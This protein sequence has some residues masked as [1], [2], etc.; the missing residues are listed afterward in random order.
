MI[1]SISSPP[2][3]SRSFVTSS[4]LSS[5]PSSILI[6][7]LICLSSSSTTTLAQSPSPS[8]VVLQGKCQ[9]YT[10]K[11]CSAHVAAGSQV[12]I[13]NAL[14]VDAIEG[15][16]TA[17]GLPLL[18]S[19]AS[20][21]AKCVSDF[22]KW[23]CLS[24]FPACEKDA[25][26]YLR[27]NPHAPRCGF[28]PS[29]LHVAPMSAKLPNCA[30]NVLD[31]GVP[32]PPSQP[33][34]PLATASGPGTLAPTTPS[35][36]SV[37]IKCPPPLIRN[38][39]TPGADP[40]RQSCTGDCCIPCPNLMHFYPPR[41]VDSAL[42]VT[43]SMR[44][45]SAA[46]ALIVFLSFLVL[47][48]KRNHPA[49]IILWFS[50]SIFLFSVAVFPNFGPR[51]RR[52]AQ[53]FDSVTQSTQQSNLVCAIQGAFIIFGSHALCYWCSFLIVNLHLVTVWNRNFFQDP[54][55]LAIKSVRFDFG[56]ICNV[57]SEWSNQLFFYP[58]AIV[59]G[60]AFIMHC[61]TVGY[62]ARIAMTV[63]S[64]AGASALG[65]PGRSRS[66]GGS[67]NG[68]GDNGIGEA[69]ADT[70]LSTRTRVMMVWNSSWR[71]I[72]LSIVL[73]VTL[74]IFWCFFFIDVDR[75][76]TYTSETE[77]IRKWF[78]CLFSDGDQT[79]CAYI[80]QPHVPRYWFMV[81]GGD[82]LPSTAGVVAFLIF[83]ARIS[84]WNEWVSFSV[85]VEVERKNGSPSAPYR[86]TKVAFGESD[87]EAMI[88]KD[89]RKEED[90]S[91][92][93]Q[94][95]LSEMTPINN[96]NV[97]HTQNLTN[98]PLQLHRLPV[99]VK[100][101]HK[102]TPILAKSHLSPPPLLIGTH[103]T[104]PTTPQPHPLFTAA[105]PPLP[106]PS[107]PHPP[108]TEADPVTSK[109]NPQHQPPEPPCLNKTTTPQPQ[110]HSRPRAAT[111]RP[112]VIIPAHDRVASASANVDP[113][114]RSHSHAEPTS[115]KM[116]G[117]GEPVSPINE[118]T[119]PV[120]PG[121][122]RRVTYKARDVPVVKSAEVGKVKREQPGGWVVE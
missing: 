78:I 58:L 61:F 62:I 83:G 71:S 21:E 43:D 111:T 119:S 74:G 19:F 2:P 15:N 90:G 53:C 37:V 8:S 80:A 81:I 109:D 107:H 85:P 70:S 84:L 117:Y 32:Y 59:V 86:E 23:S 7:I 112:A 28:L 56:S 1:T 110:P 68:R 108:S 122:M 51:S 48:G 29:T 16:L 4:S 115:P 82:F 38:P 100:S 98:L 96:L 36:A 42:D 57:S 69:N 54:T 88:D 103:P 31:F 67:S 101:T 72:S 114:S 87:E 24:A 22:T 50:F 40:R 35:N 33:C 79:S 3:S 63:K 75:L 9:P 44:L 17:E 105:T 30:G 77:F 26:Q 97:S 27:V 89:A 14:S 52:L 73:T 64:S 120:S 18:Q 39:N 95:R 121:G 94:H 113:R 92:L 47:P 11:L 65:G 116:H 12:F 6:A 5:S 91:R 41:I 60:S 93:Y 13:P 25:I 118:A 106:Q 20:T 55:A 46:G 99:P 76:K 10:G 49:S 102:P 104:P 34:L 66:T 45:V